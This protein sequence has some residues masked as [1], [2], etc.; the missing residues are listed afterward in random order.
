MNNYK[1][2][3]TKT[4]RVHMTNYANQYN[5]SK[6]LPH[7]RHLDGVLRRGKHKGLK[8]SQ[9]PQDYLKYM[10]KTWDLTNSQKKELSKFIL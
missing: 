4:K 6:P 1:Y 8:L 7:W 5:V 9:V 10:Y 3:K 2:G